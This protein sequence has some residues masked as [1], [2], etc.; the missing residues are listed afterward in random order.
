MVAPP[1]PPQLEHGKLPAETIP[2][3]PTPK[4]T[5]AA[6]PTTPTIPPIASTT[7]EPSITI[8]ALEFSVL[9]HTFQTLT[10]T[11]STIFQQM[12]E[13]PPTA[14]SEDT[15]PTEVRIP[16]PQDE[17]PTVT[18]TLEDTSSSPEALTT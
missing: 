16:P 3:V 7:S 11:H 15:T 6:P 18:A 14:P 1:M 13:I 9:V 8:S 5:S 10:T 4:A 17:P 2:P 12:D